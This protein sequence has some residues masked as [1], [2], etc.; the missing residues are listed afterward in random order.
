LRKK[1]YI[2]PITSRL[3]TGV[4][5][6]YLDNFMQSTSS[7]IHY[8]NKDYPSDTGILN[9]IRF[10]SGIDLMFLNWVENI[11]DKK[12]GII[13]SVFV[14]MLLRF[15]KLLGIK[16][17]WTL[18]NKISHSSSNLY[19]KKKLF[20]NLLKRSDLI[21]T[22]SREGINFAESMI[23]GVSEKMFYFPH[24]VVPVNT[25]SEPTEKKFDILIWGS[26]TPYKG[27]DNFLEFLESKDLIG[28]YKVL[29]TGKALSEEFYEKIIKFSG[30]NII[31]KN[32]FVS[33]HELMQMISESRIILF[34]YSGN[35]VL[36]SGA[37][38]DSI[39]YGAFVVGPNVGAF[40]EMGELGIIKVYDDF[41]Q[42]PEIIDNSLIDD[43]S[44]VQ[45]QKI[46]HFIK[47]HTW[48]KFSDAFNSRIQKIL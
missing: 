12:G 4:Y 24:P 48:D 3:K 37:L 21:I 19:L 5:N 13:Q 28:N 33:D 34:T 43:H 8:T 16:I 6:P 17:I 40:K 36:S 18:H 23:Q 44:V 35:S 11:P 15:K 30:N 38:I 45:S 42:L 25:A 22:H 27:I 1:A 31:I 39:S 9:V 20:Y 47:N 2:Y 32:E 29:I 46:N 41:M 10:L 14:L 26:L 7:F